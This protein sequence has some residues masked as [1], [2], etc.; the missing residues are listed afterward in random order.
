M[1]MVGK[2]HQQDVAHAAVL[3]LSVAWAEHSMRGVD[4]SSWFGTWSTQ[5]KSAGNADAVWRA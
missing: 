1:M 2:R 4:I 5:L 3:A